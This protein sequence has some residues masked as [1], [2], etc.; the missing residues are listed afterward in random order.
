VATQ[1]PHRQR[2]IH[3]PSKAERVALYHKS[4]VKA[5]AEVV[6]AAGL[7]HPS[8]FQPHHF[9]KRG[10]GGRV[11]TYAET[12]PPLEPG[13]LL[14]G[15][16]DPRFK[17]A[18]AMAQAESFAPAILMRDIHARAPSGSMS[19]IILPSG[20]TPGKPASPSLPPGV[21]AEPA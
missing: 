19:G 21:S 17:M 3:V 4:T 1:D 10:G 16:D 12:Y 9:F 7:D 14:R 5:L 15:T 8:Q 6:A 11:M 2:A 20:T 13:E 18:W